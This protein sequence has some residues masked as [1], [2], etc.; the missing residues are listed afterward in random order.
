[1]GCCSSGQ[2]ETSVAA[3]GGGMTIQIREQVDNLDDY[4]EFEI[5][6]FHRREVKRLATGNNIERTL[7]LG[8]F[9]FDFRIRKVMLRGHG[10]PI[11]S[12]MTLVEIGG[13]WFAV[14]I[15]K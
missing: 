9:N 8:V 14:S 6:V 11:E 15:Q 10:C 7:I 1:M 3:V 5:R 12:V 4:G 13:S 2:A